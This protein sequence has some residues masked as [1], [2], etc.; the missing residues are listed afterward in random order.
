MPVDMWTIGFANHR[1][2]VDKE[3][4]RSNAT[5]DKWSD[6]VGYRVGI[7]CCLDHEVISGRLL[8]SERC[9]MALRHLSQPDR[10]VANDPDRLGEGGHISMSM[11]TGNRRGPAP[12]RTAAAACTGPDRLSAHASGSVAAMRHN[13]WERIPPSD[14]GVCQMR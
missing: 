4:Y 3:E 5:A 14:F 2:D 12:W 9:Q 10:P 1:I 7:A 13:S 6:R 11:P 8:G